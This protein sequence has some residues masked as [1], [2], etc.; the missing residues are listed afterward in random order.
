MHRDAAY[1]KDPAQKLDVYQPPG[2]ADAPII[3]M[4][5]GGG[6]RHGDKAAANVVNN[7]VA[8]YLPRGYVFVS[9]NYRLSSGVSPV[10]Q[11][12]DVADALAYVQKHASSWGGSARKVV[13]MGHSAG[14]NLVALVAADPDF[15]AHANASPWLGTV[16]LDSAAYNVGPIMNAPHLPLYDTVFGT[17]DSR[18]AQSSPTLVL[19]GTPTPMLLVC[20]SDRSDSC[21]QANAFA[22]AAHA[23]GARTQV[24]PVPLTH[25]Q[26]N[27]Q[28][29]GPGELT[30]TIDDF[31]Q[32]LHLP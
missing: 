23:H 7:K 8:H 27:E 31:L 10:A 29:G 15:A 21:A 3:L 6:W 32:L 28:V 4:V 2:A 25:Q 30:T 1:G 17:D 22:A 24:D 26:I 9:T 14:A 5:H 12:G 18:W 19:G 11:A 20:S 13:L 16:A